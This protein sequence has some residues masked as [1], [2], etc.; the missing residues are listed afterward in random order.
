MKQAGSLVDPTELRFDF[1]HHKPVVARRA[2]ARSR[3]R[4]T[5]QIRANAEVT[6]EEMTYDDAIKAGA[7]AFFG[8]KYGDRVTV[9]RMGDFS[10]ELCG[11]THVRARA[12]SASS[13]STRESGVAAGVRRLEA[14]HRRG[15]LDEIRRHEATLAD[16]AQLLAARA[17]E[18]ASGKLEKLLA[19]SA[20]A[21]DS[22]SPE[23][24][25]QA[26]RRRHDAT[27]WPTR[28]R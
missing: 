26:R 4:S 1:S 12:T 22:A 25:A 18:D 9:V 5:P 2:R 13:S 10:T 14:V 6:S 11:G 3:T 19:Q 23:L 20:R 8:D 21:R 16:I 24:Q 28:G 27:S 7:L 17:S 15:A